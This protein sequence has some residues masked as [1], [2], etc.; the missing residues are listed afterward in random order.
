MGRQQGGSY[1]KTNFIRTPP[2]SI[3]YQLASGY[4]HPLAST[5]Y[6]MLG[7]VAK[8]LAKRTIEDSITQQYEPTPF[9]F[10]P[11]KVDICPTLVLPEVHIQLVGRPND[12]DLAI[13]TDAGGEVRHIRGSTRDTY[14]ITPKDFK[15]LESLF[16]ISNADVGTKPV[17][18]SMVITQIP[19]LVLLY[20]RV[21]Y[22]A[23]LLLLVSPLTGASVQF[24][25][26]VLEGDREGPIMEV[27]G[28]SSEVQ[29]TT[30][31]VHTTTLNVRDKTAITSITFGSITPDDSA[32]TMGTVD[33]CP[34]NHGGIFIP[35]EQ[36]YAQHDVAVCAKFVETFR[37]LFF[38]SAVEYDES[39]HEI[40]QDWARG[41]YQTR[42]GDYLAHM[43]M[44]LI[45][46]KEAGTSA[47]LIIT[48]EGHYQGSVL[49]GDALRIRLVGKGWVT[50]V[51]TTTL[52]KELESCQSHRVALRKVLDFAGLNT[53]DVNQFKNLRTL[54]QA[55]NASGEPSGMS[56]N[57][58]MKE[59][60]K[61]S[62]PDRPDFFNV[63]T[64]GSTLDYL[65][66]DK[67]VPSDWYMDAGF[68]FPK[69]KYE[70]VL[71]RFGDTAP[72]FNF[73]GQKEIRCCSVA[74]SRIGKLPYD[75]ETPP[76]T[77]QT[78]KIKVGT[79]ATQ[80][81]DMLEYGHIN[82]IFDRRLP[83]SRMFVGDEKVALWHMLD[84]YS[85]R[86]SKAKKSQDKKA[87]VEVVGGKKRDR[88]DDVV[89]EDKKA[90][91]ARFF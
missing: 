87:G 72:S 68:F 74:N 24:G 75:R 34:T 2:S 38:E 58:I 21:C 56:K 20:T 30:G 71:S 55:V 66:S 80:W 3:V 60:A 18:E 11:Y 23:N 35:Y 26:T 67:L 63:D 42:T 76:A 28:S 36:D 25:L 48:E 88:E 86:V 6:N 59:L 70:E 5:V 41:L 14:C 12:A 64:L 90:K 57:L 89:K 65:T 77:F 69:D 9:Y 85:R 22:I 7:F 13:I 29:S 46:A 19:S 91:L 84:D 40:M 31:P 10:H 47:F 27:E 4:M 32:I 53:S 81:R 79:A 16:Q 17:E 50:S 8:T 43:M 49:M 83:G 54:S 78:Q 15:C 52:S 37:Q 62:F 33:L 1:S 61:L 73:G 44:S 39:S 51:D 45:L 82:G